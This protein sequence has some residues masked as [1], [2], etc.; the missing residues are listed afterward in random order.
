M[1]QLPH[2][3]NRFPLYDSSDFATDNDLKGIEAG[4]GCD[5][6]T[7]EPMTFDEIDA[8]VNAAKGEI[9]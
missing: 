3:T 6:Q 2:L 8:I 5:C 1:K 7:I 4:G 9:K